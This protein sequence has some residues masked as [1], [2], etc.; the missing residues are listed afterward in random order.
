MSHKWRQS[1][2]AH[3]GFGQTLCMRDNPVEDNMD[4][5]CTENGGRQG[6]KKRK[7]G[8]S[9]MFYLSGVDWVDS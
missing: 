8:Q 5:E 4:H 7:K 3:T 1:N 9:K 6:K 2:T